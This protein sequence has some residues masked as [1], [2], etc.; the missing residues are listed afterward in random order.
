[1]KPSVAINNVKFEH[2]QHSWMKNNT[3]GITIALNLKEKGYKTGNLKYVKYYDN[4]GLVSKNSCPYA[5]RV[6]GA[7]CEGKPPLIV[8]AM[9]NYCI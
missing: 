5:V 4:V 2:Y 7:D 9:F 1:M 3:F 8:Q 6:T